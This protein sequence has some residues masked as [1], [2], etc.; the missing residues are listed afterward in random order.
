M[1]K[2]TVTACWLLDKPLTS[3]ERRQGMGGAGGGVAAAVAAVQ[4]YRVGDRPRWLAVFGYNCTTF[5]LEPDAVDTVNA[6]L[7]LASAVEAGAWKTKRNRDQNFNN[8]G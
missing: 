8:F 3:L 5:A 1:W 4:A 6:G 7:E 2:S